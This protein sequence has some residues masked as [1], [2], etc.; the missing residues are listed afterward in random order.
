MH[1]T[2][3]PHCAKNGR[4][5]YLSQFLSFRDFF[6]FVNKKAKE[7][8]A[9]GMTLKLKINRRLVLFTKRF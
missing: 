7:L 6:L 8:S 4:G 5:H 2:K 3:T 9:N 1:N